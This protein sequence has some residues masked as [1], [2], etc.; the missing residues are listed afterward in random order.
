M[1]KKISAIIF[2]FYILTLLQSSFFAHFNFFGA[3]PNLAFALFF[4]FAFFAGSD[5]NYY[6]IFLAVAAGFFLDIFSYSYLG[7]SVILL[8]II[9]ILLKKMQSSLKNTKNSRPFFYFLPLFVIFFI[10]YEAMLSLSLYFFHQY[11]ITEFLSWQTLFSLIYNLLFASLLFFIC[12]KFI[13][14]KTRGL[15]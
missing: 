1:W 11:K 12:Q 3:V 2:I 4:T 7:I 13:K 8:I 5:K 10:F 6:V 15:I 14:S 9:G